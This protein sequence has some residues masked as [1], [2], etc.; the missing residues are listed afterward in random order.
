MCSSSQI[1]GWWE[2]SAS[3]DSAVGKPPPIYVST[4]PF[5]KGHPA[6]WIMS[7]VEVAVWAN[8]SSTCGGWTHSIASA[9]YSMGPRYFA[10]DMC[11]QE[12]P[13][14]GL[15]LP[16]L[17]TIPAYVVE[18]RPPRG[19]RRFPKICI[20]VV[21]NPSMLA[22][23]LSALRTNLDYDLRVDQ[24]AVLGMDV[25]WLSGQQAT[26]VA[27]LQLATKAH[28]YIF[29]LKYLQRGDVLPLALTAILEDEKIV[30]V[31]MNNK[32]DNTR[33]FNDYKVVVANSQDVGSLS[34]DTFRILAADN[35]WGLKDVCRRVLKW[36][37]PKQ[38][39]LQRSNWESLVLSEDQKIYAARDAYACLMIYEAIEKNV[40]PD[41]DDA[42]VL[43]VRIKPNLRTFTVTIVRRGRTV[44]STLR[45]CHKRYVI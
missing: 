12:K 1:I 44:F 3:Q 22:G 40:L 42:D 27:T 39:E 38:K 10:T 41:V 43:E 13:I 9:P 23:V 33:L 24:V 17:R 30:K 28:T 34:H 16:T 19:L 5:L 2:C 14:L 29:Q 4:G 37:I 6:D 26:K 7:D 32:G 18:E 20:T 15:A 31:G 21:S 11:C 8:I 45:D 36:H 25:E 35:S